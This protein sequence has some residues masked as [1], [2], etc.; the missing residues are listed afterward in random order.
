MATVGVKGLKSHEPYQRVA[1]CAGLV[2]D[3]HDRP[4][5]DFWD[6]RLSSF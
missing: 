2:I 1:L 6:K 5:A 3:R 4:I